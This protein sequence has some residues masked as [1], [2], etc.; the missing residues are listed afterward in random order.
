MLMLK[1]MLEIMLKFMLMLI[2]CLLH[3]EGRRISMPPNTLFV[4]QG[5]QWWI[6]LSL[7]VWRRN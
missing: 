4:P 7:Q 1:I 3:A 5:A 6:E 2:H